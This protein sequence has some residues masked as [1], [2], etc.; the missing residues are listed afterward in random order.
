MRRA[1]A[2]ASLFL[3]LFMAPLVSGAT[4]SVRPLSHRFVVRAVEQGGG[5]SVDLPVVGNVHGASTDFFTALDV[6]NNSPLTTEVEFFFTPADGS[7]P[8]AGLLGTLN[9][10]DNL[11]FDDFLQALVS[12]GMIPPNQAENVF[13]SLLLTFT[14]E[15]FHTG[16]EATAVARVF[17]RATPA[18]TIGLAYRAQPIETDG[19]HSLSTILSNDDGFVSNIGIENLGVDDNGNLVDDPVVVRLSFFDT[20]T[21]LPTGDQPTL[22][23]APG[24]VMQLNDVFFHFGL[25][26]STVLLFVDEISGTGQIRGYAVMKDVT[27]NAGAFIFMQESAASTF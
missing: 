22:T 24:Q 6:T 17:S 3:G 26:P 16:T 27:T 21:G 13:G 12:A 7:A 4:M 14:N 9:G 15:S 10:Y 5:F 19:P 23:L 18:G 20:A 2:A 11:H 1:L 25:E 8:R